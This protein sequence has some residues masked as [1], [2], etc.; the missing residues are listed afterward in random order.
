MLYQTVGH[1][2]RF[3]LKFD[4]NDTEELMMFLCQNPIDIRLPITISPLLIQNFKCQYILL[5][6]CVV[7][8]LTN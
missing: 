4:N 5:K 3:N 7:I 8:Y 2:V 6:F 1:I